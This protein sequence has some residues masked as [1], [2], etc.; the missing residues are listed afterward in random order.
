MPLLLSVLA[1]PLLLD[2]SHGVISPER[3]VAMFKHEA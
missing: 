2:L 1:Q 3:I